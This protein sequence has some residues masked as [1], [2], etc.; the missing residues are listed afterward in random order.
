MPPLPTP[1]LPDSTIHVWCATFSGLHTDLPHYISLLSLDEKE[2]S[3]RFHFAEDQ[4]HYIL[5]RGL[6]RT[7]LGSYINME[8][9]QI[10]FNYGKYGKPALK[11]R[12][13]LGV[14]FNLAHSNDLILYAIGR[15]ARVG[16]DIEYIR[17]M[18]D[19]D[20]F[21]QHFFSA[22]EITMIGSLSG[23]AKEE[24]FFKL[25][26]CKEAFLKAHGNGLATPL[27][28]VEISL[29][30]NGTANL[31]SIDADKEKARH[32]HLKIFTP[33]QDYQAAIAIDGHDRQITFH[34]LQDF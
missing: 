13:D 1:P 2:R 23:R 4:N 34:K 29:S 14:E 31:E 28:Q 24:A 16:I 3:Q 27:D 18:P 20:N 32:W 19:M 21:A 8:P 12:S 25:W 7:L 10:E 26:T 9:A 15:H 6:L 30:N 33:M 5:G 17:P 22:D 11:S